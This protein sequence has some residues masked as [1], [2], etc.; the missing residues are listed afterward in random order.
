MDFLCIYAIFLIRDLIIIEFLFVK[1]NKERDSCFSFLKFSQT[2]CFDFCFYLIT[3]IPLPC[4][5]KR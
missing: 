4:F 1:E 3:I 2:R 5:L